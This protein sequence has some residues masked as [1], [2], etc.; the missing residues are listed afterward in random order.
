MLFV[1]GRAGSL[2]DSLSF[3]GRGA[4]AAMSWGGRLRLRASMARR[5][6]TFAPGVRSGGL[7]WFGK[8][9]ETGIMVITVATEVGMKAGVLSL[10]A[11]DQWGF[12]AM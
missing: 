1:T 5:L 8:A 12:L 3:A 7:R 9:V 2:P 6:R 10:R 11:K 4:A